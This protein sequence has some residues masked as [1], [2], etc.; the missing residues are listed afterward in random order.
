MAAAR[1]PVTVKLALKKAPG[2]ADFNVDYR[3]R[4]AEISCDADMTTPGRLAK[5]VSDIGYPATERKP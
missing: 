1:C 4:T 5:T 2:M 3:T